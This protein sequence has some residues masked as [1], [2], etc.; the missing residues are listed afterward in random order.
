[1]FKII[2]LILPFLLLST[3]LHAQVKVTYSAQET[4]YFTVN[5]PDNWRVNVGMESDPLTIPEGEL[6]PPRIISMLPEDESN[7][8][9]AAWVPLYLHTLDEAQEYLETL[10]KFLVDKP[11]LLKSDVIELNEMPS[12]YFRGKGQRDGEP[13]DFF[14][15][16][17]ELSQQNIGIAIYIGE[18][19]TTDK[20]LEQLRSMMSS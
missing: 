11:V 7:L 16:L 15:M 12:R 3:T 14:V 6:A 19:K 4:P 18:P 13:V 8:W 1:M 20:H 5:I 10:D 2:M 17:F 9:F